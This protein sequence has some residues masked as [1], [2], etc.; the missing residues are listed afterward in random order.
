MSELGEALKA[1]REEKGL[2]LDDVQEITKIQKRYLI[3]IENG[4]FD[5][6][7]GHF[8]TRAFIK[9]YAE[10]VGL[11]PKELF[12]QYASELPR[13]EIDAEPTPSRMQTRAVKSTDSK[14]LA[15]LPKIII[16]AVVLA[17]LIGVWIGVQKLMATGNAERTD[18]PNSG[19]VIKDSG[20]I[21]DGK[22]KGAKTSTTGSE[23]K[24][25]NDQQNQSEQDKPKITLEQSSGNTSRYTITNTDHFVLDIEAK[26]G[27]NAWITAAKNDANG[28]RLYYAMVSK[29]VQGQ[30]DQS[31]H[32]DLT[33]V[34]TVYVK[35]GNVP[36]T[37]IKING[38][39]FEFPDNGTVQTLYFT[40][41]KP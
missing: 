13:S 35:V 28:E 37:I 25:Q 1:A 30:P 22:H 2:S 18:Q 27:G 36:N 15:T 20:D 31:F 5:R 14:L 9:S 21:G 29:G 4:D 16:I 6:L 32:K 3:A 41:K 19:V 11:D 17:V 24:K 39:P 40:F 33:D 23:T 34:G 38:Q 12:N 8:Y 26:D 10:A 7:P